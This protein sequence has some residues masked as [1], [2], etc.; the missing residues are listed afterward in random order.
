[1]TLM[2]SLLLG[3]AAGL[4]AVASA[5]AADLPTRKGA[6]AA[7][8]VRICSITVAGKPIVGWTL[9]GSDTCFKIGGYVTAQIEGGNISNSQTLV[10]SGNYHTQS[11]VQRGMQF[12]TSDNLLSPFGWSTRANV[13][14]DAASNTAYGPLYA[15]IELQF[16][17][18]N[19]FDNVDTP[20]YINLA[21]VT[22]AGITAGKAPSFFSFTG[23]GPGWAN[24]FS[25]DQ[26]GFN[27]PDL[28]AYTASFGGGFSASIAIQSPVKNSGNDGGTQMNN[29]SGPNGF[30]GIGQG[31][32]FV[33]NGE[34]VPDVVANLKVSQ[35]WGSAQIAGVLHQVNVTAGCDTFFSNSCGLGDIPYDPLHTGPYNFPFD[36][37]TLNKWGWG[38]DAG[39]S[40]NLPMLAAGDSILFTGA[41][42]QNAVWFSGIPDGMWGE[43]GMVNGNGQQMAVADTYANS[44]PCGYYS[45]CVTWATPT[46]WSVSATMTHYFTPEIS[47]SPLASYGQ[48]NWSN[49]SPNWTPSNGL[50][51]PGYNRYGSTVSNSTSW[52]AGLVGHWDPVKN[53]DFE[54]EVLYQDTHTNQP[55]GFKGANYDE[56]CF[57]GGS[58][59]HGKGIYGQNCSWHGDS[60][61]FAARFEMTRNF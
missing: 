7:E 54:M 57:S 25:P 52:I 12:E 33:Y 2:K 15:H 16:E 53:L 22:W 13:S 4:V 10:Y 55:D 21:Y 32:N 14:M 44:F 28:L 8:Y 43:N 18:G 45:R 29:I 27:Q 38:V 41:Y 61:G 56:S 36:S 34:R 49:N 3:S 50:G 35:G 5:Q 1:M 42:T 60:S 46:A 51:F 6:P 39:I 26:Q 17:S 47:I 59:F 40:F 23:G 20:A 58:G 19:G 48:I 30:S 24:F 31:V 37:P 9:P 11:P